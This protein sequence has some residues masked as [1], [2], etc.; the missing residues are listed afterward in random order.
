MK[1]SRARLP[2][3][4]TGSDPVEVSRQAGPSKTTN[5]LGGGSLE[6]IVEPRCMV[7]KITARISLQHFRQNQ[8]N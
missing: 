4:G 6:F 5:P 2:D 8:N 7:C 3:L 1:P